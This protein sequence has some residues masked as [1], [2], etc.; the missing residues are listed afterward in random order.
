MKKK[1]LTNEKPRKVEANWTG[2]LADL[3]PRR[4][5]FVETSGRV[6][7]SFFVSAID[8]GNGSTQCHQKS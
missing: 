6:A 4:N 7:A 2:V 5:R 3:T 1:V 8:I